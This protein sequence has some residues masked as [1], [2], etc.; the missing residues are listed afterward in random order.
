MCLNHFVL[1]QVCSVHI[2]VACFRIPSE[3]RKER[4]VEGTR[5]GENCSEE[6]KDR[7]GGPERDGRRE[8][9]EKCLGKPK[10]MLR[11]A[12]PV[13]GET[14]IRSGSEKSEVSKRGWREGVGD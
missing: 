9:N 6:G 14:P 12:C 13:K 3:R 1:I 4:R 11:A 7:G 8:R 5:E 10:K 2:L